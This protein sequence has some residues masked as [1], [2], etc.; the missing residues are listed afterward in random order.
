MKIGRKEDMDVSDKMA[1]LVLDRM[2]PA[3]IVAREACQNALICNLWWLE[4][5]DCGENRHEGGHGHCLVKFGIACA[6]RA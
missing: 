6:Q 3:C 5:M 2:R 4:V 1:L